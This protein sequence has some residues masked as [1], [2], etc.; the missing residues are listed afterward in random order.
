MK[1]FITKENILKLILVLSS[2]NI[3]NWFYKKYVIGEREVFWDLAVNYCAGKI[4]SLGNSPYGLLANNPIAN[5]T[6]EAINLNEAFAY[7][8]TIP[9]VKF[10]SLF[11]S[12][13][14][15]DLKKIWLITVIACT[16]CIYKN[17]KEVFAKKTDY[18]FYLALLLFSFGGIFFQS[19]LTGNI[20][21]LGFAI[22]SY[23]I[24]LI[25]KNNLKKFSF[26]ILLASLIKPHFFFFIIIGLIYKG[27]KFFKIFLTTCFFL[28]FIYL[29]DYFL[30][31][32][33]FFD[34]INT[35]KAMKE[36]LWFSS[37]G[38]GLGI[39]S[40]NEQIPS[41]IFSLFNIYVP[42]GPSTFSNLFWFFL[43][44]IFIIC[45]FFLF[46]LKKECTFSKKNIF[47]AFCIIS[48]TICLPRIA[49]YELYLAIP[50]LIY[51]S[52]EFFYSS[53]KKISNYGFILLILILGIHDINMF[54]LINSILAFSLLIFNF[55]KI[56]Y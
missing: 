19:L 33:I 6:K 44:S 24:V 15:I 21:I 53:N 18:L 36:D 40:I 11:N 42:S 7:N 2:V 55:K 3:L 43:S 45:I 22:I 50:T 54:F 27:K 13:E 8:Y 5:C 1:K 47:L 17:T 56:K 10:F 37:F 48:I 4:Y 25:E 23:A 14:F 38:G 9:L 32:N 20:S 26:F 28:I 46:G 41:R 29:T 52:R 30:N 49:F 12:L 51:I 39:M 31:K 34:F 16:F 35:M